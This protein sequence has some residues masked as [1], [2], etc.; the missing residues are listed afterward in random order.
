MSPRKEVAKIDRAI[1]G[2]QNLITGTPREQLSIVSNIRAT[3]DH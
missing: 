2:L 3:I 1:E